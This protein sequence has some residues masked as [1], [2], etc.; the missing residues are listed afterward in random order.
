MN[1]LPE[2]LLL[3]ICEIVLTQFWQGKW[4]WNTLRRTR[5]LHRLSLVSRRFNRIVTPLLY[6][7]IRGPMLKA[8]PFW[9]QISETLYRNP[10][11][12]QHIKSILVPECEPLFH[13]PPPSNLRSELPA[14]LLPTLHCYGS[15][16]EVV[17]NLQNRSQRGDNV[18]L[19][20]LIHQAPSLEKL[21]LL[22]FEAEYHHNIPVRLPIAVEEMGLSIYKD[23]DAGLTPHCYV[24]LR[25]LRIDL[26]RWGYFPPRSII[27]FLSL[28]QLKSLSLS[29]WGAQTNRRKK[30]G[31]KVFG[32]GR[33]WP[34]R[35][36]SIEN[37]NLMRVGAA[38]SQTWYTGI[39]DALLSHASSLESIFLTEPQYSDEEPLPAT[40]T[41]TEMLSTLRSLQTAY[42]ILVGAR[43][44][45]DIAEFLPSSLEY[46]VLHFVQ[47]D[48]AAL[49]N[50]IDAI[51]IQAGEA[52][53][54]AC[55]SGSLPYLK[56]VEFTL[57]IDQRELLFMPHF[58][59]KHI[60]VALKAHGVQFGVSMVTEYNTCETPTCD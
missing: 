11:L 40:F 46:L 8:V 45:S 25:I 22:G 29:A 38:A 35:S 20:F 34:V 44:P 57:K 31:F 5:N 37:L 52:I 55:L 51:I 28:P 60:I 39:Y 14:A 36:S 32:S 10:M 23:L 7:Q 27:P 6:E 26:D 13:N 48:L 12:A 21:E 9:R 58:D 15:F 56:G 18:L 50:Q 17:Y 53:H 43:R 24:S 59:L 49:W 54:S 2:E 3:Q 16:P 1:S 42:S 47:G 41:H 33:E 19:T 30:R 4:V